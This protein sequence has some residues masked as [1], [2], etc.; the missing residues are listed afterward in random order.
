[1]RSGFISTTVYIVFLTVC[2]AA[3]VDTH[4]FVYPSLSRSLLMEC[5]LLLL[6]LVAF[7]HLML[8]RTVMPVRRAV[9]IRGTMDGIYLAS[10]QVVR[11]YGAVPHGISVCHLVVCHLSFILS[12]GWVAYTGED[13]QRFA[14][15][16]TYTCLLCLCAEDG[17]HGAR[18][19]TIPCDGG[20]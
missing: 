2:I 14:G 17:V 16:R 6:A 5:G 7:I 12:Q 11:G 3:A 9:R 13:L 1:M 19:F 10:R 18:E 8:S 4:L 20:L 15:H